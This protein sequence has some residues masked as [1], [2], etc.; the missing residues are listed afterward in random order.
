LCE[1]R[2][3][4]TVATQSLMLLNGEFILDQA[5]RLADRAAREAEATANASATAS[6]SA[7]A[8]DAAAH[9]AIR[10][11]QLAYCRDPSDDELNLA[12]NF[13]RH[14][15]ETLPKVA[16]AI[17]AGRSPAQQALTNLCQSLLASN[18]FLYIE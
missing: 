5:A 4:S 16:G 11:W 12:E 7:S 9:A 3:R 17:P 18:E 10:A 2:P 6:P 15:I 14:Q 13:L 8:R 1:C